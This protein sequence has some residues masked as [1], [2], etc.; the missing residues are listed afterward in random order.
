MHKLLTAADFIFE[1]MSD[2]MSGKDV[3][4]LFWVFTKSKFLDDNTQKIKVT[5]FVYD[6]IL[7]LDPQFYKDKYGISLANIKKSKQQMKFVSEIVTKLIKYSDIPLI[8]Y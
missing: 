7:H 4:N 2:T 1:E 5:D 3:G 6:Y 8:D